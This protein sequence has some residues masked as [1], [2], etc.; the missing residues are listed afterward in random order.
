M[1]CHVCAIESGTFI[2]CDTCAPTL[3]TYQRRKMDTI[4]HQYIVAA[5]KRI[6]SYCGTE[7]PEPTDDQPEMLCG[8]HIETKGSM[9]WRRWDV[10]NG[11]CTCNVK[12]CH[13]KRHTGIVYAKDEKKQDDSRTVKKM[14][15]TQCKGSPTCHLMPLSNGSCINHQ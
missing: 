12:S 5:A 2:V 14:K 8:D 3:S 13:D 15:R 1:N 7:F 6:C 4:W 10:T 9:P 11:R